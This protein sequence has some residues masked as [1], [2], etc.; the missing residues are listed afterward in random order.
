[1]QKLV[2]LNRRIDLNAFNAL[3]AYSIT[4]PINQCINIPSD[5]AN[6]DTIFCTLN[7]VAQNISATVRLQTLT[8]P[9]D[10]G[11][12]SYVRTLKNQFGGFNYGGGEITAGTWKKY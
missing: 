7:N 12:I 5:L 1:M 8:V 9:S 3:G 10:A 4:V 2:S 6:I 11:V